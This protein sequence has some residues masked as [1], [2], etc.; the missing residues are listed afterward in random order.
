MNTKLLEYQHSARDKEQGPNYS[1]ESL[2]YNAW[3]LH[4]HW[5]LY[6]WNKYSYHI[7]VSCHLTFSGQIL[8]L[9]REAFKKK[10]SQI[11]EK[12]GQLQKSKS[13]KFKIWTF[14]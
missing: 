4:P 8:L 5:Q 11:M 12:V 6:I 13:P 7:I 14:W 2:R 10:K 3:D 1:P 9:L